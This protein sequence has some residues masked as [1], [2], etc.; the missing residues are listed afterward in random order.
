[1]TVRSSHG[2]ITRI[3]AEYRA[4]DRAKARELFDRYFG[5]LC[6]FAGSLFGARKRGAVDS[7]DIAMCVMASLVADPDLHEVKDRKE[8]VRLLCKMA[9]H[10]VISEHRGENALKRGHGNV[11]RL[12]EL[13]DEELENLQGLRDTF[14]DPGNQVMLMDQLEYLKTK[15][16]DERLDQI[17]ELI[18]TGHSYAEIGQKIGLSERS[19]NRKVKLIRFIW[20]E[21]IEVGK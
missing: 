10:R 21:A 4:G 17:C 11:I 7:E 19:V 9:R 5:P 20:K 16:D 13:T 15:H 12:S 3:I 18:L 8:L 2:T 1:M 6:R 14:C